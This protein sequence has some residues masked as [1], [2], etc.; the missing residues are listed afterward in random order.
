MDNE[1]YCNEPYENL[2]SLQEEYQQYNFYVNLFTNCNDSLPL[3]SDSY[4]EHFLDDKIKPII[5]S[6]GKKKCR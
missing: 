6:Y 5:L 3:Y 1:S 4:M 2:K